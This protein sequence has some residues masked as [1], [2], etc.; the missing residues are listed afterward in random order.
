MKE[1][2]KPL[3]DVVREKAEGVYATSGAQTTGVEK[4][5]CGSD[6]MSI[7]T[8]RMG[9]GGGSTYVE[10]YGC[11]GCHNSNDNGNCALAPGGEYDRRVAEG[12]TPN[13]ADYADQKPKWEQIYGK[14][15]ANSPITDKNCWN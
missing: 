10:Y 9:N 14:D 11:A 2:K 7:E 3:I 5:G 15:S 8:Y 12:K 1:Y 4:P 13:P 6:V